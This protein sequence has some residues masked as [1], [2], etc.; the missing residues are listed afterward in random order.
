MNALRDQLARDFSHGQLIK[1]QLADLDQLLVA[2]AGS[3]CMDARS[4]SDRRVAL[5]GVKLAD[6]V[7][8]YETT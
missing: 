7:N 1:T 6:T 3:T 8:G 2:R 4:L 5:E